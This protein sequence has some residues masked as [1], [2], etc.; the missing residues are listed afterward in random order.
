[1]NIKELKE[2]IKDL[3]DD[4]VVMIYDRLYGV[5]EAGIR[6][7]DDKKVVFY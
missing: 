2:E 5:E 4:C 1:M 6:E 3:P 7:K